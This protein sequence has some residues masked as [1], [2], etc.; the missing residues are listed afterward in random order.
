MSKKVIMIGPFVTEAEEEQHFYGYSPAGSSRFH[1]IYQLFMELGYEVSIIST[2]LSCHERFF[3][4][5][6]RSVWQKSNVFRP[7]LLS[8][9]FLSVVWVTVSTVLYLRSFLSRN[10]IDFIYIYNPY[11]FNGLPAL[12]AK[13]VYG[14]KVIL[15]YEDLVA[16]EAMHNSF[17]RSIMKPLESLIL[18]GIDGCVACTE[19]FQGLLKP[20]T[21]FLILRGLG[22]NL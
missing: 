15:D 8:I 2:F 5:P 21:P 16:S 7:A 19:T 13:R 4:R 10:K 18:K 1:F 6:K 17:Y 3:K 20:D 14:T 11:V 22:M 12:Y 9:T